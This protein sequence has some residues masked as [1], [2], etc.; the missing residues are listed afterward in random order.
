MNKGNL[1]RSNTRGQSYIYILKL[2]TQF[3]NPFVMKKNSLLANTPIIK[4]LQI[5]AEVADSWN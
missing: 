5:F 2:K 1:M 3:F 4:S